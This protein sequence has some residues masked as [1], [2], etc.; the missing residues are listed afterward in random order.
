M[1]CTCC[2]D[3]CIRTDTAIV[4]QH[5][6]AL[7]LYSSVRT[8]QVIS[9]LTTSCDA[10]Y[11]TQVLKTSEAKQALLVEREAAH[12]RH[13][14]QHLY[15]RPHQHHHHHSSNQSKQ[16][17][18]A[19]Q[20]EQQWQRDAEVPGGQEGLLP[21]S[22]PGDEGADTAAAAAAG[23]ADLP[24]SPRQQQLPRVSVGSSR[25]RRHSSAGGAAAAA[26]AA[27]GSGPVNAAAGPPLRREPVGRDE[28]VG[29]LQ[30]L[31]Q[32]RKA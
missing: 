7:A 9:W 2:L 1:S 3:V 19:K 11:V 27:A 18:A 15:S 20:L 23:N 29:L 6:A 12:N 4:R 22:N 13:L 10:C 14:H 32:Q 17:A 31:M 16:G 8:R 30:T 25:K 26:A 5:V 24:S 28:A 21:A